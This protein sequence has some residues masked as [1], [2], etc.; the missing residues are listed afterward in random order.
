MP[1]S[2]KDVARVLLGEKRHRTF[3]VQMQTPPSNPRDKDGNLKQIRLRGVIFGRPEGQFPVEVIDREQAI[4]SGGVVPDVS[5]RSADGKF[6]AMHREYAGQ[7]L[8][9]KVQISTIDGH[10]YGSV[11]KVGRTLDEAARDA[12]MGRLGEIIGKGRDYEAKALPESRGNASPFK[13][14][15]KSSTFEVVKK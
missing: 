1:V 9:G 7:I 8:Q 10:V 2:K 3:K 14:R 12:G 5:V 13:R 4:R 11:Q 6:G 15:W